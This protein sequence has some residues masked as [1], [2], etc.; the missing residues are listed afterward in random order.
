M[1]KKSLHR[2]ITRKLEKLQELID[3]IN[4]IQVIDPTEPET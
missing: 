4:D 3:Q 1:L 2:K